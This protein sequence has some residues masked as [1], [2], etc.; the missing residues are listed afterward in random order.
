MDNIFIS[1]SGWAGFLFC[2][3]AYLL[4]NLKKIRYDSNTYQFL[5][6]V[7]AFGLL[8]SAW[9]FRDAPNLMSNIVWLLI[10]LYGIIRY[11]KKSR[12]SKRA[13]FNKTK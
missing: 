9:F 11:N 6:A 10:A 4:L 1:I 3:V 8:I 12:L 2:A 13:R 5:N 7:G